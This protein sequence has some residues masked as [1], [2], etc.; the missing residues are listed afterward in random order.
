MNT[1][2][3]HGFFR[4]A[5]ASPAL[6]V[7]DCDTNAKNIIEQAKDAAANGA[8]VIVFPELC[9]TGYTC[10]DLF[11]Q[12]TLQRA[13]LDALA[14]IANATKNL[15]AVLVVGLPLA[16]GHSIYNVAAILCKGKILAFVPKTYIPNYSEFYEKRY[17]ASGSNLSSGE[18]NGVPFGT[19]ILIS[20]ATEKNFTLAVEICED[21]WVASPP[22]V[23]H[24][25]SGATVIANLSASNEV[26]GKAEY[27]RLLVKGQSARTM[28][29]YIYADAGN[30]E[31]T[32]D[33]VFAGHNLISEN[34]TILAES[35]LFSGKTIYADVDL[36]RIMIDR[37]KTTTYAQNAEEILFANDYLKIEI[38]LFAM[39]EKNKNSSKE[40][41]SQAAEA[42]ASKKSN[43]KTEKLIRKIDAHP[44]VP[45]NYDERSTRCAEI[46][47]MQ[48]EGLAKR[49]RHIHATS[50]VIGISGGLDSTLALLV[51]CRAFDLCSIPRKQIYAITMPCFGTTDRTY[52]NACTLSKE[53]GATLKEIKIADSVR[54]HLADIGHDEKIHDTT[55]ENAQARERTQVLMDFANKANGLVIGTGDLSELALGW[56]TYNGDH[57]SMYG[58]NGSIPK[59]LVRYLVAHF[60]NEDVWG[61]GRKNEKLSN[62][63]R[64]ILDTPV[65]PELIP[66]DANGKIVQKTED[67]VGPYELH[68]FFL[69][70]VLRFGFSPE[71]IFFLAENVF[72]KTAAEKK[73]APISLTDGTTGTYTATEIKKW[74]QNF[75]RR[76]FTQ[77]FKRSCLPDG[78]KVG[79]VSLSPRG[80]WRM[81]SDASAHIWLK[82]IDTLK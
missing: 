48:A 71:K 72:C 57:I 61:D 81:P 53:L 73:N 8:Q 27:R 5:A 21:L 49:L 69:Y 58:V 66:P 68:D 15:R 59:T 34:G 3:K 37:R 46:I 23:Q 9:I 36:E 24:A 22:S 74:L 40:K 11:L 42:S 54:Q 70:Y 63:L 13:A 28:T 25:L 4:V 7:A 60:A 50:A 45:S 79:T 32:T 82:E 12:S 55:Y 29:A 20:D 18:I 56:C 75:Y 80:D 77:Q 2:N 51:T 47:A 65:S 64:D 52:T 78:A 62:V 6:V 31:S 38:D 39:F 67:I 44:F 41:S 33:M 26:V 43:S 1:L 16:D 17:F 19:N 30:D 14:K 10:G 35:K 76:F